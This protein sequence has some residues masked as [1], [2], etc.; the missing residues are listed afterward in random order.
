MT[1]GSNDCGFKRL[2][3]GHVHMSSIIWRC[4]LGIAPTYLLK[5]FI[6]TSSC[7]GRQSLRSASLLV[8]LWCLMLVQ[9]LNNIGPSRLRVPPGHILGRVYN[10]TE[11][12]F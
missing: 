9:P 5:L 6:L 2:C 7:T 1:V 11:K 4:V 8:I 10:C 12:K 3:E